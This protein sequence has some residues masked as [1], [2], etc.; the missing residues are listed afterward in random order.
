[1]LSSLQ[2]GTIAV[3]A[4]F[5]LVGLVQLSYSAASLRRAQA[6]A[7][8]SFFCI[9]FAAL[10]F[11]ISRFLDI[12][13]TVSMFSSS[14]FETAWLFVHLTDVLLLACSF[15]LPRLSISDDEKT[16]RWR[17][18]KGLWLLIPIAIFYFASAG[19]EGSA[20]TALGRNA[21][22]YSQYRS[23]MNSAVGLGHAA[24]ALFAVA[25]IYLAYKSLRLRRDV[26]P[27]AQSVIVWLLAAWTIH[28]VYSIFKDVWRALRTSNSIIIP[29]TVMET[30]AFVEV[31][32]ACVLQTMIIGLLIQSARRAPQPK[33][34]HE[35]GSAVP[36]AALLQPP[37]PYQESE[38]K[39]IS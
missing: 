31:L 15:I 29:S 1:M 28:C 17:M 37:P 14:L 4:L 16:R 26:L 10:F 11:F 2:Q 24:F 5:V 33:N 22:N 19:V 27:P 3:D 38:P 6:G 13:T 23:S 8:L 21:I 7:H 9:F 12:A 20:L 34:V 25:V 35:A 36:S 32:E 39:W 30:A 18:A